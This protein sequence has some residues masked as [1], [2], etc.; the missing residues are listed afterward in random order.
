MENNPKRKLCIWIDAD[1]CP[2]LVRNHTVKMACRNNAEVYFVANREIKCTE[3]G[4]FKMIVCPE[5]KDAADNYILEHAEGADLVITKD[6]IFADKLVAKKICVINDR[7][8]VFNSENIKE[9]LS[10]RNF[11]LQLSQAGVVQHFHE[12]YDKKKFALFAN[13]F[14]KV[15]HQ[16][17]RLL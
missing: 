4:T 16:Q 11:D 17:L 7:G 12:G 15:L 3:E 6:I 5:E 1:S 13:T 2:A 9:K 10:E 8:T 14:D